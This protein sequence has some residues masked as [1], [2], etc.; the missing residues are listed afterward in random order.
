MGALEVNACL[1]QSCK[2]GFIEKLDILNEQISLQIVCLFST[3]R[4]QLKN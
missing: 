2:M 3:L 4:V 1:E